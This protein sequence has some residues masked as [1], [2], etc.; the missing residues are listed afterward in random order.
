[1]A[2]PVVGLVLG[3]PAWRTWLPGFLEDPRFRVELL[4]PDGLV[5]RVARL[6]PAAVVFLSRHE[7]LR[8]DRG[9][10]DALAGLG[11][12]VVA[13]PKEMVKLGLDKTKMARR[14]SLVPGLEPVRGLPLAH[15]AAELAAGRC[16]AV[17]AKRNDG[18][19]GDDS[20]VFV[21][22]ER[23][24]VRGA[25]LREDGYLFQPFV[26]GVELSLNLMWHE[27]RCN[28]YPVV[29]KGPTDPHGVH[30]A[31]RT[32]RCPAALPDAARDL[33]RACVDYLAPL[34]PS[35]PV[36]VELIRRPDGR[37]VLLEVNPRLSATLRLSAVAAASN[38]FT[39][40]LAA[41]AGVQPLGRPVAAA[42]HALEWPLSRELPAERRA[43]LCRDGDV[44]VS[45]RVTLAAPDRA[46]LA[47]RAAYVRSQVDPPSG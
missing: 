33:V 43:A 3:T 16:R 27:G 29:T 9:L 19:D 15:A 37:F 7:T 18:T 31:R 22:A 14:A 28:V 17:V 20:E 30:P 21:D 32:R 42:R 40:L 24:R 45:T 23:L 26:E 47:R 5:A 2:P 4:E 36:E 46:A 10:A 35:G 1:M 12:P 6:R 41:A 44:W 39:D 25:R 11:V 34:R 38:P 8:R 13:Q